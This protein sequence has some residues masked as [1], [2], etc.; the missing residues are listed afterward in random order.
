MS[1]Q[2]TEQAT[3]EATTGAGE[4]TR[5]PGADPEDKGE[6][7]QDREERLDPDNR[8]DDVEVDNTDRDFDVKKG[9]FTDSEGYDEAEPKF[10]DLGEQ[11]A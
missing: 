3:D 10:P 2:D 6:I 5:Q 11:G 4:G 9:M 1:D 8:P 7:E